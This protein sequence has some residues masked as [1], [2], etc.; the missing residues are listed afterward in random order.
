MRLLLLVLAFTAGWLVNGW[1]LEERAQAMLNEALKAQNQALEDVR[2]KE[3][4][5]RQRADNAAKNLK[6]ALSD[7]DSLYMR[8]NSSSL[9]NSECASESD[10]SRGSTSPG[11][12][13]AKSVCNCSKTDIRKFQELY[14]KQLDL[15]KQC[16]ETATK[17]NALIELLK[18][19]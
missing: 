17:Y 19:H 12:T 6:K 4:E 14:K 13:A 5:Q 8:L 7:V 18:S 3:R 15:A 11:R 10:M 9:Y 16:D 2:V 1:R